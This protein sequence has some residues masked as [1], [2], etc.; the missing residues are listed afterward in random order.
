LRA[1]G[2]YKAG[3]LDG[4]L[5]LYY[6][7]G[8]LLSKSNYKEGKLNGEAIDYGRNGAL[9]ASATY[10]A[11][12]LQSIRVSDG[13]EMIEQQFK[14]GL[15]RCPARYAELQE[16]FAKINA[17]DAEAAKG[18]DIAAERVLS[19]HRL[20]EYRAL[21]GVPYDG[22][23]LTA[24]MNKAADAAAEICQAINR[25]DHTP[26]NPG[27]AKDKYDFASK[28]TRLSNLA[29]STGRLT[30]AGS[31]DMYM[32]DSDASNIDRVGHRRW[33]INPTM[34]IAG[35]GKSPSGH[36]AAMMAHDASRKAV[37]EWDFTAFPPAGLAPPGYFKA[38]YA[39][40][41]SPNLAKYG[42]P[43]PNQVKITVSSKTDP[44]PD[45]PGV[46]LK[47]NYSGVET[48]GFGSGAAIIFRPEGLSVAPG[49]RYSVKIEGIV[50]KSGKATIEYLVWFTP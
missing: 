49:S 18:N 26:P 40:S 50:T 37:P 14:N 13:K 42:I 34:Q 19:L 46:P 11:G 12:V 47:L 5:L 17:T 31:V 41:V 48:K 6:L 30:L 25:L 24:D 32:D 3:R 35:F 39:W 23:V 27:W 43:D 9:V 1:K 10:A 36:F 16:A 4:E 15:P 44:S 38:E 22:L 28:A 29:S 7:G 21:V 33:C 8:K 2:N 20:Q 45:K